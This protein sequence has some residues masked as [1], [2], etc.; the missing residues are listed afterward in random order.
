MRRVR[1]V[2]TLVAAAV[3]CSLFPVH[4]AQL[5]AQDARLRAQRDTL[6]QIRREREELERQASALASS[7]HD[8]NEEVANLDKRADATAR[9][10]K[11][12]DTQ[13]SGLGADVSVAEARVSSTEGELASRRTSL[14]RRLIEIYKRGPMQTTEALLSA[15]SF[16]ELIARYKY[17]HLLAL[18]D[19]SLVTR[20]Q[21]L[22]DQIQRDRDRLVVLR[23]AVE[24]NRTD[25][26]Q[27][28]ERL[29]AIQRERETSL[30]QTRREA[31][32]VDAR[33]E[34]IR[35]T[36]AQLTNTIADLDAERR[37]VESA[38]PS[39][40]RSGSSIHTN[41]YGR[42]DWPVEGPLLYTF[43]KAQTASNTTIRWNGVGIKAVPNAPVHAVASGTV[44]RVGQ[45]GTY[46]LT[47][48]VDHGGGDYSIYGSLAHAEVRDRQS[49]TKGQALGNV[50][51]S[52]PELPAHL[53]FEIRHAGR[54]GRPESVDPATWLKGQR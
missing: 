24:E 15:H 14:R 25:K 38:R 8:L 22:R 9:I 31:R 10:V 4:H 42:L 40:P 20:V 26:A 3:A 28:E 44:V 33:L 45:L 36:E 30:A 5:Q 51:V 37:R 11:A 7:V 21:Q 13:L 46:G 34:E 43:G 39:A 49:I 16:G 41:D 53:H 1:R 18:H 2:A 52:D 27:E 35:A 6:E 17:L 12:L 32:Q 29:R 54:D 48:I 19:R 50:G 23:T 47:V